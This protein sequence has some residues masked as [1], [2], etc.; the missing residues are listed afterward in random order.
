MTR[1]FRPVAVVGGLRFRQVSA[2][3][4]HTC[5]VTTTN[6]AYCWGGNSSGQRGDGTI[7]TDR[8]R[9]VA[10][11]GGGQR[12]TQ[13]QAGFTHTCGVTTTNVAFCWGNN[14]S[15]QLGDGTTTVRYRPTPVVGPM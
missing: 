10:V 1:R 9:P 14:A 8:A 5:G 11:V 15:G 12:Y 13:V 3:Y 4:T 6:V 2:G 7:A